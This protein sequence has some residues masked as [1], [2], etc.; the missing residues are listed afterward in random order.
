L[1]L[2][3]RPLPSEGRIQ[4]IYLL[5]RLADFL[6]APCSQ[7]HAIAKSNA[8]PRDGRIARELAIHG[9]AIDWPLSTFKQE[10]LKS[11]DFAQATG[12]KRM[13]DVA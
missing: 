9:Q 5:Q 10:K 2:I 3:D 7:V 6:R 13:A 11:K 8:N 12:V 4:T 1:S